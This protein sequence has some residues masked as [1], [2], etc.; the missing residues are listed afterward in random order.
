LLFLFS[1]NTPSNDKKTNTDNKTSQK[2]YKIIADSLISLI[3]I[4]R[5]YGDSLS[6]EINK[7]VF[8]TM[9]DSTINTN[10]SFS[11][12]YSYF[13]DLDNDS[14]DEIV[15]LFGKSDVAG[16]LGIFD[17]VNNSWY[18]LYFEDYYFFYPDYDFNNIHIIDTLD[19]KIISINRL[20]AS[21]TGIYKQETD[22][23]KLINGTVYN[24]L[25]LI[26][27]NYINAWG[28][29]LGMEVSSKYRFIKAP[30]SLARF[31]VKYDYQYY[32]G[33]SFGCGLKEEDH[34]EIPLIKGSKTLSYIWNPSGHKYKAELK[35]TGL[36]EAKLKAFDI[37]QYN[38]TLIIQAFSDEIDSTIING[39]QQESK[40]LKHYINL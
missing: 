1:C 9:R 18:C 2:E 7:Q 25:T 36:S 40:L 8:K 20:V 33:P 15:C 27:S 32:P 30:P 5:G 37:M 26:N 19:E 16:T 4:Y 31:I 35:N 3:K 38:D 6:N 17:K 11:M 21:G 14:T 34:P 10:E 24:V 12:L 29:Q 13:I 39:T 22:F 28:T 23:L